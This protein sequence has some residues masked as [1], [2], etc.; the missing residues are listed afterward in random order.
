MDDY[1]NT[2]TTEDGSIEVTISVTNID[3]P[4]VPDQ[5][6]VNPAPGAA[7]KLNV[8]WTAVTPSGEKPVDGYDVQYQVKDS[9]PPAWGSANVTING[10][11]ATI[12]DLA[13]STTYEVQVQAKNSEGVSGWS[14]TDEGTI[15]RLLNVSFSTATYSV[16]EGS[17]ATITVNVSPAADRTLSIPI[18]LTA[19]SAEPGDYSPTSTTVNFASGDTSKTIAISTTKDS[20]RIAE[21]VNLAFGTLPAAVGT[22]SQATATLTINDTTPAP[23]IPKNG[24]GGNGGGGGGTNTKT[25]TNTG[26]GGGSYTP[27]A[28][29]A[30]YFTDGPSTMRRV[31]EMSEAGTKVSTRVTA[32]DADG[33]TLTYSLSGADAADFDI[34]TATGQLL[35]KSELDYEIRSTYEV[36]L[37]VSDG[38]G[39]S[40]SIVVTINVSDV[41]EVPVTDEDN[42]VVVLVDPDD[43]TE[44]TTPGGDVT[45]TF[46]E[47]SR[48]GLFFVSITTDLDNCDWDSL[49]DPP[50]DELRVC[51]TVEV[52]DTKGNPIEG[53]NLFDSPITIQF[54]LDPD[55]IGTDTIHA[56]IK[57]GSQWTS[58]SF[59]QSTDGEGNTIVSIGGVTGSDTYALGSNAVQQVRSFVQPQE[60]RAS[61]QQAVVESTP[62]PTPE[63]TPF[64][65]P[66]PTPDPTPEPTPFPTP[67]PTPEPTP[68]PEQTETSTPQPAATAVPMPQPT[69]VPAPTVQ[70]TRMLQPQPT[71]VPT[72]AAELPNV[73]QQ[74][75]MVA[76]PDIADFGNASQAAAPQAVS[77]GLPEELGK[78]RIWPVILLALGM[79][80]ELVALGLFLKERELDKRRF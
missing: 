52:Y 72:L 57:S 35:T 36:T 7:P 53:A 29:Q 28:N 12:T 61:Q 37:S 10:T 24:G 17:S 5:P 63:P 19:G 32:K 55:D 70:P 66:K 34:N 64:P 73:L 80:M 1:S 62:E 69:S 25:P 8:S 68:E 77:F 30:P 21:T 38:R 9:N 3:V 31:A 50:A 20:D 59:T 54:T 11:T 23:S 78:L 74:S 46:P 58:V 49:D 51:V 6:T 27:P 56:F 44:V 18:S 15:P 41:V 14:P 2:D 26:G 60:P 13:Y 22:G 39:G 48:S 47:D 75:A 76:P 45:V 43:E 42:Q 67:K 4:D 71:A 79:V 40:D 33:N 65:T 16:N